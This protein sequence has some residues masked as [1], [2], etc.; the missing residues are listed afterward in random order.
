MVVPVCRF[1]GVGLW[2]VMVCIWWYRKLDMDVLKYR[3]D[4]VGM[5]MQWFSSI[6]LCCRYVDIAV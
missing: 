4:G 2:I 5:Y 6:D 1:N 3:L